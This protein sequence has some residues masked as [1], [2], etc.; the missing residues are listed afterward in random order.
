MPQHH[1]LHIPTHT[2]HPNRSKQPLLPA[3]TNHHQLLLLPTIP[4]N[5]QV[6]EPVR[7]LVLALWLLTGR[8]PPGPA[9]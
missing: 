1:P 6:L 2:L 8:T 7:V 5:L 4:S 3:A 9:A